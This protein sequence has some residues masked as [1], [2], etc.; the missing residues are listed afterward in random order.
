MIR[1]E[2]RAEKVVL[3]VNGKYPID[4]LNFE[5]SWNASAEWSAKLLWANLYEYMEEC[6][7]KIRQDAYDKGWKDAKSHN[8]KQTGFS[9][10]W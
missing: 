4:E 1:I 9:G 10:K 6:L 7:R 2:R 5:F 3:I 8:A